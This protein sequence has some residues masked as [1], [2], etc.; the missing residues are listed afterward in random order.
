[1]TPEE[2]N[3]CFMLALAGA[4]VAEIAASK[5][6]SE[7]ETL[8]AV[9]AEVGRRVDAEDFPTLVDA[10]QYLRL[11]RMH[12]GLWAAAAR[13]GTAEAKQALD[14]TEK[15]KDLRGSG[16]KKSLSDSVREMMNVNGIDLDEGQVS[17]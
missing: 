3:E 5:G 9:E 7:Q 14:I 15:Q 8:Q 11:G 1:M 12:R 16:R 4:P 6:K 10:L 2:S 13:G 17:E